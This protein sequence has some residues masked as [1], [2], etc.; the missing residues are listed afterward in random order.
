VW[1]QV[2]AAVLA[3]LDVLPARAL[4]VRHC[5]SRQ[6]DVGWCYKEGTGGCCSALHGLQQHLAHALTSACPA[7]GRAVP[8]RSAGGPSL[9]LPGGRH[10]RTR[11]ASAHSLAVTR[12]WPA[13]QG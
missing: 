5:F 7:D 12:R 10:A 9:S 13:T 3:A 8:Q 11:T 1:R 4:R 2:M 6:G